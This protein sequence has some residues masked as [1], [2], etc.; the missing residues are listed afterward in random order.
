[1]GCR[2]SPWL[3]SI[4]AFCF[5]ED[6]VFCQQNL[7]ANFVIIVDLL[8]VLVCRVKIS[9]AL[10]VIFYFVPVGYEL[11]VEEHVASK[12]C[13]TWR[14][15]KDCMVG[16]ANG[17]WCIVKED[18]DNQGLLSWPCRVQLCVTSVLGLDVSVPKLHLLVDSLS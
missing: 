7:I 4:W 17:P 16:R 15:F 1:M 6:T 12:Y 3:F 5:A 14:G 2:D 10:P 18:I 13:H 9:L 11:N 8:A